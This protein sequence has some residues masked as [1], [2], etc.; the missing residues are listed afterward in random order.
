MRVIKGN[1]ACKQQE[2]RP[3]QVH[4]RAEQVTSR[5][6]DGWNP[7]GTLDPKSP[8]FAEETYELVEPLIEGDGHWQERARRFLAALVI[9]RDARDE[10]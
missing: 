8:S 2:E 1:R 7:I 9:H 5:D 3:A 6:F 10:R 4:T